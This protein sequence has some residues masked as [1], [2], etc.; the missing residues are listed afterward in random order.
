MQYT[1]VG[2]E[3]GTSNI[4]VFSNGT[5]H[6][7]HSS[8]PNFA[9]IEAG[10]LVGDESVIDLFDVAL[11]AA[12]KFERLS[13]RVTTAHGR[14]YLDGEE[15]DNALSK[16]VVRFI[17][18]GVEDWKPLVAFFENVLANPQEHSREQ[19]YSWLNAE[20]FTITSDGLIVGYKSV[21]KNDDE[22]YRSTMSGT[23]IVNGETQNG[24]INQKVGDV[25]E[26]PRGEVTHDP[27]EACSVGLH[28]G[29]HSYANNYSGNTML[30]VHVNPRDVVSVPN[31]HSAQKMRVCRYTIIGTVEKK[32]ESSVIGLAYEVDLS[33][34]EEFCN[35]PDCCGM[36]G[37][38]CDET[39]HEEYVGRGDQ[40]DEQEVDDLETVTAPADEVK[41]GDVYETTDK[42]R[43]GTKFRVESIEGDQA[44]GKSLPSNLTRKVALDRLTSYRYRKA[45]YRYRTA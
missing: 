37:C 16:Q 30:E 27:T 20:D 41:V 29:T 42:R 39:A 35:D 28:V 9:E 3:D 13:D 14:L 17:T 45:N 25:V 36:S 7:A 32:Y 22:S 18:E 38:C 24:Y 8:H 31:D 33:D 11:S 5:V 19:L 15:V 1:L 40:G 43:A 44:V 12:T 10:V 21:Y 6:V 34:E 26:M 2:T 4:T 23:A